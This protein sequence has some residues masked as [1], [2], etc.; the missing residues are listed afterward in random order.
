MSVRIGSLR[1]RFLFTTGAVFFVLGFYT[2]FYSLV[3]DMEGGA[4]SRAV[5]IL[6][7][8][9]MALLGLFP[10]LLWWWVI[11]PRRLVFDAAGLH[12]IDP[13]GAPW[14]VRWE[15]LERITFS[16][17][18]L[19][20]RPKGPVPMM[21]LELHPADASFGDQ[22]PQMERWSVPSPDGRGDVYRLPLGRKRKFIEPIDGAL[23]SFALPVYRPEGRPVHAGRG[24]PLKVAVSV[25]F[26]AVAWLVGMVYGAMQTGDLGGAAIAVVWVLAIGA[27]LVRVWAGGP[28]AIG[29]L[30]T[31]CTSLGG[32]L[33]GAA[34]L[35]GAMQLG[36]VMDVGSDGMRGAIEVFG[37]MALAGLALLVPGRLL[38][39]PD[40]REWS[41]ERSGG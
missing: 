23:S 24:R 2:V 3:G 4:D 10:A 14:T 8:I 40:V 12:R 15:E 20:G 25:P 6:F 21:A 38:A 31:A 1:T 34:V 36:G 19:V 29:F 35:F 11:R 32:V 41:A 28:T 5:S 17:P 30:I 27:W 26:L 37:P 9:A 7:G 18:Q 39:R 33:L 16:F 13:R 22:H